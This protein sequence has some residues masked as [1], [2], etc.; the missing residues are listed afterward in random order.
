MQAAWLDVAR[1]LDRWGE[2]GRFARL[3]L[4]DDDAVTATPALDDLLSLSAR[5]NVPVLLGVIPM[6]AQQ[7]LVRCLLPNRLATV[8]MHGVYHVNNAAAGRKKEELPQE[9]GFDAIM[10]TLALGR[11]RLTGLFGPSAATWYIPPWNRIAPEVARLLPEAG[12]AGLSCFANANH[13]ATGLTQRNTHLDLIDWR[14]GRVGKTTRQVA[15][16]LSVQLA[17]ARSEDYR[18]VGVLAHHLD[19]DEQAWASLAAILAATAS[20]PAARWMAVG[21]LAG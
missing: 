16:E 13:G 4:R 10:A 14:A 9:L 15:A 21:E 6:L 8:A 20:H 3:W 12:F 2:A 1:E 18:P 7:S 17:L 19:H 5:H 11:T